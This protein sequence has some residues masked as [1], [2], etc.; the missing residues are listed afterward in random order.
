MIDWN[1]ILGLAV[2]SL[3]LF[4]ARFGLASRWRQ[5]RE[6]VDRVLREDALKHIHKARINGRCPTLES[7]AGTLHVRSGRAAALLAKMEESGLV[8]FSSGELELTASGREAALPIIRAHR[9]W[10]SHLAEHTGLAENEWHSQAEDR[11]H[12]LSP[13]EAETLSARMSHPTH[14][15]HG[16]PIPPAGGELAAEKGQPLNALAVDQSGLITHIEDEP[17]SVY[18]RIA[19]E[20]LCPGMKVRVLEKGPQTIRFRADGDEHILAPIL[21]NNIAVVPLQNEDLDVETEFLSKLKPGQKAVVRG[22]SRTCHG[23]ERRRLLD[24]GFVPGSE[25]GVEMVSPSGDPTAYRV[26][27]AVI[28]LRQEQSKL[29]RVAVL[30]PDNT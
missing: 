9:L 5:R 10:E 25:V 16:D 14:D 1:I 6:R 8:T 3:V 24:L 23:A 2:L 12:H 21:A 15:P 26:R 17:E 28:A 7:V 22:L 20:G 30:E 18:A 11:E 19:A 29:I 4:W 27:G 13:E